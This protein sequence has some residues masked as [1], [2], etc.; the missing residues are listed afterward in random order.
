[1][2][3]PGGFRT[4]VGCRE[5]RPLPQRCQTAPWPCVP[6]REEEITI[7]ALFAAQGNFISER[8]RDENQ[9]L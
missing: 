5:P 2:M 6:I 1:M 8:T 9:V 7:P 3:G 4:R